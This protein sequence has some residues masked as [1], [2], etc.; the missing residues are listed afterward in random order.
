MH[1]QDQ[2]CTRLDCTSM[3]HRL[4]CTS[5]AYCTKFTSKPNLHKM[6][7]TPMPY[8]DA[9]TICTSK[10]KVAQDWAARPCH[11]V[12]DAHRDAAFTT[13]LNSRSALYAAVASLGF[14]CENK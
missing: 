7:F 3:A 14:T 5:S 2:S 6:G 13:S 1:I 9:Y 12:M 10:I 11:I 4:N 8:N